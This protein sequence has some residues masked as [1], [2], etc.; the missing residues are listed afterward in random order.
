MSD[1]AQEVARHLPYMRRYARAVTGSQESGD[2]VVRAGLQRLLEQRD[3]LTGETVRRE[4]YRALHDCLAPVH[5]AAAGDGPAMLA[6]DSIL[7]SRVVHLSLQHRQILLLT[8][9]EG[10]TLGEAAEAMR[11]GEREAG[12][13]LAQAKAD[14]RT[15]RATRILVIEDEPVIALD[16]ATTVQRNGHEVVGIA[17]TH[18][19]AVE[20][21]RSEQPGLILADIQL[22]DDSSGIDA[23]QEILQHYQVPVIF[24]TAFPERLLTGERPEPAFLI[25][26]PFDPDT[27]NVSISQALSTSALASGAV[28]AG[29]RL[30]RA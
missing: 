15:Q 24:I 7:A 23:V 21:A 13:L 22:A 1:L 9:L 6:N 25:T 29:E 18:R 16:I 27:L 3:G 26:K 30:T 17:A 4:L 19:E 28:S 10:M 12:A 2:N 5:V 11:L 14:L 8:T 20:L